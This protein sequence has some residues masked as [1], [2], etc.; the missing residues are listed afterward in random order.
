MET[1]SSG[2]RAGNLSLIRFVPG[3]FMPRHWTS[4]ACEASHETAS[5][6]MSDQDAETR[7]TSG[8][9]RLCDPSPE[10]FA[11]L[12]R[13]SELLSS[14]LG[15]VLLEIHHIGSTAIPG[16]RAKPIVDLVPVVVSLPRLD[17]ARKRLEAMG[18]SWWGEYGIARRRY[19]TLQDPATGQR[20]LN[21][22]FFEQGDPGS[23]GMSRSATICVLIRRRRASTRRSNFG[24]RRC[25]LRTST[26][27]MTASRRGY[28]RSN[29]WRSHSLATAPERRGT[30]RDEGGSTSSP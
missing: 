15:D 13:E 16:I 30:M 11:A 19:C 20:S 29:R 27:T 9:V 4:G 12:A 21:A 3:P 8:P 10:W 24:Q 28:A 14:A 5:C 17:A 18:Y 2:S 1:S 23:N 6:A 25:I 26:T 22:H 7:P